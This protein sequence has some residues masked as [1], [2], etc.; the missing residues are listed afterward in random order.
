MSCLDTNGNLFPTKWFVW[1]GRFEI[2]REIQKIANS[3]FLFDYFRAIQMPQYYNLIKN[4][5][6]SSMIFSDETFF[7]IIKYYVYNYIVKN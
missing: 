1:N 7:D 4:F 2:L 6:T 3:G 5:L